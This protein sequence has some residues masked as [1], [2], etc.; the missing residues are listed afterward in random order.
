MPLFER[1][2]P[3]VFA[4]LLILLRGIAPGAA[5][6]GEIAGLRSL[7]HPGEKASAFTL[8]D[9]NGKSVSFQPGGGK[10]A[11][12]VFWSAFCPLCRE[13]TPSVNDIA[14]RHGAAIRVI[15][16][17]LDGKRFHNAVRS[18]VK[19]YGIAF[20]VLLDDL[21]NDFFIASD[22]YGVEKTPTAVVV[23]GSGTVQT[24]YAAEKMRE[25]IRDFDEVASALKKG[26]DVKKEPPSRQPSRLEPST[27]RGG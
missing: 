20:P 4:V 2:S 22:P 26:H 8:R 18:F 23:D 1:L 6:G 3:G 24:A 16:V 12:L 17:N 15:G 7:V 9:L 27:V 25:L 21:R 5:H 11:L 10:P 14:R 19:E 13:L